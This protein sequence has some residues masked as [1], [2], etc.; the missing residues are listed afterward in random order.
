MV[1]VSDFNMSFPQDRDIDTIS[2]SPSLASH[3]PKVNKI[4]VMA[5]LVALEFVRTRGTK[6][7]NLNVI[8]SRDRR[9]IRK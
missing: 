2:P 7:T 6:S 8:P 9:V 3:A 5:V 1:E 4:T